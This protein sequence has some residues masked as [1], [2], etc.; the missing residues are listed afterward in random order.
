MKFWKIFSFPDRRKI[1]V[2]GGILFVL[3]LAILMVLLSTATSNKFSAYCKSI[4]YLDYSYYNSENRCYKQIYAEDGTYERQ[5]SGIIDE[6]IAEGHNGR[7]EQYEKKEGK[8]YRFEDEI[9]MYQLCETF[10][11]CNKTKQ[12]LN[13]AFE[14]E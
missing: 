11:V 7:H 5:Y 14:N 1:I 3:T 13:E 8:I 2:G 4:G 10:C 6:N 12:E 9:K